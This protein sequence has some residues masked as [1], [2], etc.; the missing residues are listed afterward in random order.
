MKKLSKLSFLFAA[1]VLLAQVFLPTLSYAVLYESNYNTEDTVDLSIALGRPDVYKIG[2]QYVIKINDNSESS[3]YCLRGGLGFGN[4]QDEHEIPNTSVTYSY[5]ADI[6]DGNTIKANL[7]YLNNDDDRYNAICWI[8][9]NMYVPTAENAAE[10]KADLLTK[11]GVSGDMSDED[12]EVVQQVALWYFTNADE[13]E[14]S[15]FVINTLSAALK[16]NESNLSSG[17]RRDNINSLYAYFINNAQTGSYTLGDN[18]QLPVLTLEK[19]NV[20]PTIEETTITGQHAYLIGPFKVNETEGNIDYIPEFTC[21]INDEETSRTFGTQNISPVALVRENGTSILTAEQAIE[22]DE[23]YVRILNN[24]LNISKIDS[25]KLNLSYSYEYTKTIATVWTAGVDDQPVLK[26][27]KEKIEDAKLDFVEITPGEFDLSLRKFITSVKRNGETVDVNPSRE[28]VVD[29]QSL[30]LGRQN[31]HGELEY[32]ATYEHPKNE[33]TLHRGD[34]ITYTIRIYNEGDIDGTATEVTDYLPEGLIFLADNQTNINYGW[35]AN[36]QKI[37][38]TYLGDNNIIIPAYNP[39]DG[40]P[41]IPSNSP[42]GWQQSKNGGDGLYYVDLPIVCQIANTVEAGI[43]LR[44]IAEITADTG[45]DRD[46]EP[47][48]VDRNDYTPGNDNST[49]QEDDDDYE[50]VKVEEVFDLALRKYISSVKIDGETITFEDEGIRKPNI[51]TSKLNKGNV[52]TADYKHQKSPITV[53]TGSL[54]N[55]KLVI[56][57]EGDVAGRATKVVDKLPAGLRFVRVLSGNFES[58]E[59]YNETDNVLT[60]IREDRNEDNLAPFNGTTLD[61]ETIEIQC[62]VTATPDEDDEK[63][64]TNI[65]WIAEYYNE[66]GILDRDSDA[67]TPNMPTSLVTNDVG[68]INERDNSGKNLESPASYFKGQQDDDDFEKVILRP[69]QFDLALRKYISNIERKGETVGPETSREPKV[70]TSTLKTGTTARYIHPKDAL[71]VK[72]G[73]IITYKLRVYNEGELDGYAKEISD[74]LPSGLGFLMGYEGNEYWRVEST[75]VETTTIEGLDNVTVVYSKDGE[76][77]KLTNNSL[78]DELIKKYG[79]EVEEGDLWQQSENNENDGLFYQEVE[80]TCIVLAPNTYE[81]VLKNIAEISDDQA[82]DDTGALVDVADRDSEVD[83]V[84]DD[85]EHTPGTEVNGY[86]PGEQDDDDFEPVSLKYFDLALR[87]FITGVNEEEVTSR[88]PK[89][90]IDENGN[91][92]YEHTK[93]PV[94]VIDKDIVTYTIRVFNEG[95]I[96]GYAEEIEDDIPAGLIFLPENNTNIE[97]RWVMYR[98][99]EEDEEISEEDKLER[100]NRIYVKTDDVEK[101]TIIR[102]DYLSEAQGTINAETGENSN[103]LKAFDRETMESPD[104]RDVKVAFKVS[105]A[106]IPEENTDHIIINKAQI[107]EDSDDDE[108]STPDEWIDGDDDQDIEKIYVKE[109]DLA[110]YKWVTKTIVTVDGKTTVTETGFKPNV[111]KTE[112]EGED[113]RENSEPEP[114]AAVTLDKKKLNKTV[115]KFEYN[116]KV[117]NEG[118]IEGYATE[119]TDYIPEGLE[120]IAEDN[121]LWTLGEKDGTIVTRALETVLLQPGESRTITVIFTW[122]ND[123]NNLGQ[124]RNIAAITEDYNDYGVDDNDSTPGNED[125]ENYEKEQEDDDDFALVILVLK[126][127]A[128]S[129][130]I[131]LIFAVLVIITAGTVTIKKYVL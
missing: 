91:Y 47:D 82:Q 71:T 120:F 27:E 18:V 32:T 113:Y 23:F 114:I 19:Q 50:R 130:Y 66:D 107:T 90:K 26:V 84:W 4:I 40:R 55:Y 16:I 54:V 48:N 36:G 67:N 85:E 46:S 30:K 86:T 33:L 87:K 112:G 12:I 65:A 7:D 99:A 51:D 76:Y 8:A 118:D 125:V 28:P 10:L 78:K 25:F 95:T 5:K 37:T 64:L 97:Y 75:D 96:D 39:I 13:G 127:G 88:I 124:K 52:T 43:S 3:Y 116:I 11:A 68:Y 62:E 14:D 101:A 80:I 58:D 57:N 49:Y 81:G 119:I 100:N 38:T 83:N 77:L 29:T 89:F 128:E 110:L 34:V 108:D 56:Y 24:V 102:T 2:D 115:V 53:E 103:L 63:I 74:Y 1:F 9:D 60:L 93:D 44:N 94:Y 21:K 106:D 35:E 117:T 92:V 61:S 22:T 79:A 109:F 123:A 98:P 129:S 105:Q 72:N 111:G 122:I 6:I 59:S 70:D 41:E 45:D 31:E 121:P 69:V 73:D 42:L 15:D 20:T 131:T 126:T 104:F 17:D